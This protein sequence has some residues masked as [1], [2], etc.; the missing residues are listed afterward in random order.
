M[1]NW[2]R[3]EKKAQPSTTRRPEDRTVYVLTYGDP[4]KHGGDAVKVE[5]LDPSGRYLSF[6]DHADEGDAVVEFEGVDPQVYEKVKEGIEGGYTPFGSGHK[7]MDKL[8]DHSESWEV[9]DYKPVDPVHK[10]LG[11][12]EHGQ[13]WTVPDGGEAA[14]KEEAYKAALEWHL[15]D[16]PSDAS[17]EQAAR[18]IFEGE[19]GFRNS[20]TDHSSEDVR[21]LADL[22]REYGDDL[23]SRSASLKD[24][25]IRLGSENPDLRSDLQPVI[26]RLD[27]SKE[28][29]ARPGDFIWRILPR[30][31]VADFRSK[32]N[33]HLRDKLGEIIR[34]LS[35][36]FEPDDDTRRAINRLESLVT[37]NTD[38]DS[39]NARN[40]INKITDALG[41]ETDL[42]F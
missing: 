20:P 19:T 1:S 8:M 2:Y 38:P 11:I 35:D 6:Y 15:S 18:M 33:E 7:E 24:E 25:L 5:T 14:Y 40:Q 34:E 41:L 17:P 37:G 32:T 22:I 36:R 3:R 27:R 21:R 13:A 31:D 12:K 9:V 23:P 29:Q 10:A 39:P 30:T 4:R 28:A 42:Y 16:V 26:D